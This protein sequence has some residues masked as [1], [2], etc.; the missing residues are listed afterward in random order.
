MY[1]MNMHRRTLLQAGTLV[2]LL[3]RAELARGASILGVR[4]WPA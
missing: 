1:S 2:L 4:V 3:G